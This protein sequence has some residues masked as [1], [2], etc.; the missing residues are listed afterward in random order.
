MTPGRQYVCEANVLLLD[1]SVSRQHGRLYLFNDALLTTTLIKVVLS[2]QGSAHHHLRR[3]P[4]L[5]L[6]DVQVCCKLQCT[7]VHWT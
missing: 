7:Y 4:K 1:E 2:L 3:S 5:R 6:A